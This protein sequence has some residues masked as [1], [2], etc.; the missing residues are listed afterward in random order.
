LLLDVGSMVYR[1]AAG[2][3]GLPLEIVEDRPQIPVELID[4]Q[5]ERRA[6][7]WEMPRDDGRLGDPVAGG[8]YSFPSA[9]P[10]TDSSRLTPMQ[11]RASRER[12]PGSMP[13]S[14]A[15]KSPTAIR[16]ML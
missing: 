6:D 8:V 7:A 1:T 11:A 16:M 14:S 2:I 9:P 4:R 5:S 12:L 15:G 10:S 3:S 13:S